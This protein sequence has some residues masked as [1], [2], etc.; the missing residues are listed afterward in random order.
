MK[1]SFKQWLDLNRQELMDWYCEGSMVDKDF[2]TRIEEFAEKAYKAA[3]KE[4]YEV[5]YEDCYLNIPGDF[6]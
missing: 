2:L 1:N 6:V 3:Y 5:G 4:A